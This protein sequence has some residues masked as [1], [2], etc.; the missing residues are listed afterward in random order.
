MIKA[1]FIAYGAVALLAIVLYIPKLMQ[2]SYAFKKVPPLKAKDKR[3]ISLVIPARDE[4]K[5]IGALLDSIAKQDYDRAY[6][7]VNVIVKAEDDP[8]V[9]LARRYGAE[10]FIV[11]DQ[12]CKGAALDGY[13]KAIPQNHGYAAFVIV[14]ADAVLDEHYLTEVNNALEYEDFGVIL[15]RKRIKN[16][17]GKKSARSIA[18]GCSG[19]NYPMLDDLGNNYRS[20]HGLAC[21]LCGQGM[22]VRR[23]V[24]DLLGGWPFRTMTE[25][26]ELR[27]A[28]LLHDIKTM[29]YPYAVLYTEEALKLKEV[30][31]RRHRWIHGLSQCDKLYKKKLRQKHRKKFNKAI[32]EYLYSL[33]PVILFIAAT[34]VTMVVGA[35]HSIGLLAKGDGDWWKALVL[36]T[37]VPYA[38]MYLFALVYTALAMA[39]YH[40]ALCLIPVGERIVLLFF[41]PLFMLQYFTIYIKVKV[42]KIIPAE[43]EHTERI[44][45][46]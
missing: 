43:W 9:E 15:T 31:K 34:I 13:F 23:S 41:T 38:I 3:K 22:I 11:K 36:L 16:Y 44:D 30:N 14:D 17:L 39:A 12:N 4:I 33:A 10:I 8:T 18:C 21:N 45:Y 46:T 25:D 35:L 40:D 19:L 1:I 42:L 37:V 20:V 32:F 5:V 6:F 7:D 28:C 24:I 2:I 26:V 29:V 27:M